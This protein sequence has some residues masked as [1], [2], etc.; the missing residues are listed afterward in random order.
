MAPVLAQLQCSVPPAQTDDEDLHWTLGSPVIGLSTWLEWQRSRLQPVKRHWTAVSARYKPLWHLCDLVF[1][2]SKSSERSFMCKSLVF[3]IFL[4]M[5][6]MEYSTT[7][8]S[9]TVCS[10]LIKDWRHIWCCTAWYSQ[11]LRELRLLFLCSV[12]FNK[13]YLSWY[14]AESECLSYWNH[15]KAANS[16]AKQM[17]RCCSK[18]I[19]CKLQWLWRKDRLQLQLSCI[20]KSPVMKKISSLEGKLNL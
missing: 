8:K 10:V 11:H 5:I 18:L 6:K 19:N 9:F 16:G 17:L 4:W 14:F 1:G 20:S 13:Q 15:N 12:I 2:S 3:C 7:D